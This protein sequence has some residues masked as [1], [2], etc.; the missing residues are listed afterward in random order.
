MQPNECFPIDEDAVYD[1][2]LPVT[3]PNCARA[4]LSLYWARYSGG[5]TKINLA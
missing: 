3:N 1:A 4:H 5:L 2:Q